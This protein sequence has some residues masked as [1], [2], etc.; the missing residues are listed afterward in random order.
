MPLSDRTRRRESEGLEVVGGDQNGQDIRVEGWWFYRPKSDD[1]VRAGGSRHIM[2]VQPRRE[3]RGHGRGVSPATDQR[4]TPNLTQGRLSRGHTSN[5]TAISTMLTNVTGS[6]AIP[7]L[8]DLVRQRATAR[9]P[10]VLR[11]LQSTRMKHL[12]GKGARAPPFVEPVFT[13]HLQIAVNLQKATDFCGHL[14]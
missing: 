9:M 13:P 11:R 12:G 6:P 7:R 1:C 3:H 10:A 2:P 14:R 8:P 4:N 5:P